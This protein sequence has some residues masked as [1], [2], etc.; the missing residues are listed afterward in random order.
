M[1]VYVFGNPDQ[2]LDNKPLKML[3]KLRLDFPQVDFTE[4]KPNQ[5][6]NFE[7]Q[8]MVYILDTIAGIDETH[9]FD[10]SAIDRLTITSQSS[11]HDYDLAFQLK[12]LKK[13]G[14][15]NKISILGVPQDKEVDYNSFHSI[16][17]KFVAQDIQGS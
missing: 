5:E 14:K 3:G 4:V 11:V 7:D 6:V 1:Q 17:K 16:F 15:I 12:Y 9:I 10:E 13:L 8:S 2:E